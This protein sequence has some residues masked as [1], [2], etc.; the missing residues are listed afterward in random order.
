[1]HCGYGHSEST[2]VRVGRMRTATDRGGGVPIPTP[3]Y[4][5]NKYMGGVD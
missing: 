4:H 2:V 1:M 5:Y 3:V